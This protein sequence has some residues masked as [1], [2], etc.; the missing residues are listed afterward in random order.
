MVQNY[1]N[2]IIKNGYVIIPN[3]ISRSECKKY[4]KLL[5]KTYDKYSDK[6]INSKKLVVL[7]D[8]SL[9][10]VVYNLHNKNLSWFKLFEHKTVLKILDEILKEGSY[11]NAEPYYLNNISARCPLQGNPGQQIHLDSNLPGVNYNISY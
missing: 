2:Q 9:E 3:V 7:A 10:K 11:K 6:Y 4:K 8:K 5:E 1:V